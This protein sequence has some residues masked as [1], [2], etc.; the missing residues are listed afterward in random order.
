MMKNCTI[1]TFEETEMLRQKLDYIIER[2]TKASN[3]DCD[4]ASP[5]TECYYLVDE[6]KELR[7]LF[8]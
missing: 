7:E 6:V 2:L 5:Q 3:D 8:D 4:G 1:L